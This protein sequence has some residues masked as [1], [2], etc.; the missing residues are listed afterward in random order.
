MTPLDLRLHPPRPCRAELDGII[1]LPRAID[2]VR[3]SLPGGHMGAYLNLASIP[4]MSS[5]FY[6]RLGIAHEEF[7]AAV[8]R[9]DDDAEVAAWLRARVD[10]AAVAKLRN[11]LL[12][13]RLGALALEARAGVNALYSGGSAASDEMLLIDLIDEDDAAAFAP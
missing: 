9:A 8:A 5:L 11:Q 10:D 4:T 3:A 7:A 1:F 13:L 6:H 12:A 2:K